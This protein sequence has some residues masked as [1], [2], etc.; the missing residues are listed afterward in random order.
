M[1][2]I[3]QSLRPR[4]LFLSVSSILTGVLLARKQGFFSRPVFFFLL[5]TGCLL[6]ALSNLV[7]ELGDWEKG[8]DKVQTSRKPLSL[9]SNTIKERQFKYLIVFMALLAVGSGLVLIRIACGS[10]VRLDSLLFLVAGAVSVA[11]AILY[12]LGKKP[13]GYYGAGDLAVFLFFGPVAVAGSYY[14]MAGALDLRVF[15]IATAVGLLC[16]AVLNVNNIRDFENDKN[17]GKRTFAVILS[18]AGGIR[19]TA[20]AKV[21]QGLLLVCALLLSVV[22]A[23][24]IGRRGFMFLASAPFFVLHLIW[25][26]SKEGPALDKALPILVAGI[27]VYALSFL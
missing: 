10:F 4:T 25:V 22:F 2:H 8:T 26:K 14:L 23:F 20:P 12:S 17:Y 13:Y 24:P 19:G 27:F 5:L 11:A 16:T 18:E 9:Q 3:V 21:Y 1:W 15:Y 7:N 6:Q